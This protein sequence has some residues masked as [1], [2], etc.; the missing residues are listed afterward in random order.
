MFFQ[1]KFDDAPGAE[2]LCDHT[3]YGRALCPAAAFFECTSEVVHL[4]IVQQNEIFHVD[5]AVTNSTI[6][7]PLGARH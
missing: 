6:P 2:T 4:P 7:L 5:V 3:L 1:V